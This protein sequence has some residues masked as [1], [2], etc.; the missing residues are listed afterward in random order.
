MCIYDYT[1]VFCV[2]IHLLLFIH[3]IQYMSV[4]KLEPNTI[5]LYIRLSQCKEDLAARKVRCL[6][7]LGGDFA[8]MLGIIQQTQVSNEK[9]LV[10]YYI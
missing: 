4:S 5:Y 10:I 8:V 6:S 2:Y 3:K 9:T 1:S 7:P